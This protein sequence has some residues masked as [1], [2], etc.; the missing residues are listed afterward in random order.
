MK[1]LTYNDL[2]K[3]I[4]YFHKYTIIEHEFREDVFLDHYLS[5]NIGDFRLN[6]NYTTKSEYAYTMRTVSGNFIFHDI[7][8]YLDKN[9]K[10]L[11]L[12]YVNFSNKNEIK[13]SNEKLSKEHKKIYDL[14]FEINKNNPLK[15]KEKV[16]CF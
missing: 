9:N 16:E 4:S 3:E 10:A 12:Y 15:I 2:F 7:I 8:F 1:E 14:F 11:S 13:N 5:T 6:L